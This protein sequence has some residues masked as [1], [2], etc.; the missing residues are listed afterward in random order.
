MSEISIPWV[1][2]YRPVDLESIIIPQSLKK[3]MS[4]VIELG[5]AHMQNMLFEGSPGTGKTTLAKILAGQMELTYL[6]VNASEESGIDLIR[7]KIKTFC[8]TMAMDD[9]VKLVILDE[10]D[11]LSKAAQDSLRNLIE[12]V[13]ES[14]RFVFTCNNPEK[15]SSALKSRLKEIYFERVDE[16]LILRR[17]VEILRAEKIEL[18]AD[19]KTNL[20]KLIKKHYPDIRKTINHLQYF[21]TTGTLEIDFQELQNEDVYANYV[22]MI[23]RKKLSEIREL[24][25][26]NKLDYE[27]L[28]KCVYNS[29]IWEKDDAFKD[30]KEPQKAEAIILCCEY[31]HRG[32]NFV[33]DRETHFADFSLNLMLLM[34]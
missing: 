17:V 23:K 25:R 21:C 15:I 11:G 8:S 1:E 30:W 7:T 28:I 32:L 10:A 14:A 5:P 34:K 26:N 6:Y 18:P 19:Q 16:P 29:L 27:G 4:K 33:I 3:I 20:V 24:L 31:I 13:T 12:T 2:K 22:D 9:K